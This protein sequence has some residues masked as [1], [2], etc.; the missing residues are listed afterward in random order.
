MDTATDRLEKSIARARA[1]IARIDA[2]RAARPM[3][4]DPP[5][6]YCDRPVLSWQSGRA[7]I[8]RDREGRVFH[9]WGYHQACMSREMRARRA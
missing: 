4:E 1:T 8:L 3:H 5:C 2:E 6:A 9:S 7:D